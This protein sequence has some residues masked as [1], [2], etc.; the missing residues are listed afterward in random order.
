MSDEL[1]ITST[2]IE[3]MEAAAIAGIREQAAK[4][5]KGVAGEC[6]HCE[7][8]SARL[9]RGSCAPCRDKWGLP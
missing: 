4:I 7:E 8:H 2:N 5:E 6:I 1:D 3:M 9:V